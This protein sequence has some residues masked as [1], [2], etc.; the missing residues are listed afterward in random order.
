MRITVLTVPDCPN[1]PV[2]ADRVRTA[3][4]GR[5]ATVDYVE[6]TE[7]AEAARWGMTGSPTVLVN[8]T[9]PFASAGATASVSCRIYRHADGSTDGA[10]GVDELRQALDAA[11]PAEADG[12]VR[13]ESDLLDPVGRAGRGRRAPAERGLR[14]V[15]QAVLRH[16]ADTGQAPGAMVL[17]PYAAGAGRSAAEVLSD[18]AREDFLTLDEDAQI[19]AAYPFSAVPTV[20]RVTLAGGTQLWSMCAIDALGIPK[21]LNTDAVIVSVDPIT[22]ERVQVTS[23]NGQMAWEPASAVVFVGRRACDGPAAAVCCDALNF[24]ATADSAQSWIA[25][26]PDV[27]GRTVGQHQAEQ[28][29][30]QT[31]GSLLADH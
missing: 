23:D 25:Q 27:R 1:A 7:E 13:C 20:H 9:D 22:G 12:E 21:M 18:L 24:F 5:A 10:P 29:G 30:R 6:V 28:I 4:A 2:A 16:F 11:A 15:Q 26:H 8:G 3:L 14:A 19:R 31:F 17:E